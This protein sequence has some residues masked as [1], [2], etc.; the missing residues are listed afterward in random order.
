MRADRRDPT[1]AALRRFKP[2]AFVFTLRDG[3][4]KNVPL[5]TKQNRWEQLLAIMEKWPWAQIEAQDA[6][7]KTLGLVEAEQ[8]EEEVIDEDYDAVSASVE[9]IT[10]Q[11]LT[12]MTT[13]QQETRKSFESTLRAYG[14]M[15]ASMME[16]M[17]VVR[18][19]YSLAIKA[20]QMTEIVGA[21]GDGHDAGSTENMMKLLMMAQSLMSNGP[22][23]PIT[24]TIPPPPTRPPAPKRDAPA[25][26][27]VKG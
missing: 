2:H 5:S 20:Q 26:G 19:S 21:G 10:R 6:D 13:T 15:A 11:M 16:A 12:V 23:P 9:R 3:T 24:V 8:D 22:K 1:I 27:V 14:D 18:E 4:Q 25:N 7:G 17:N